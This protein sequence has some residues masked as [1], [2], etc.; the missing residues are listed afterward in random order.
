M[1][2]KIWYFLYTKKEKNMPNLDSPNSS[3]VDELRKQ[4]VSNRREIANLKGRLAQVT[5]EYS[6]LKSDL[7]KFK[8]AVTRDLSKVSKKIN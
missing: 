8:K 2:K 5:E 1:F 7:A 4:L 3:A 6:F